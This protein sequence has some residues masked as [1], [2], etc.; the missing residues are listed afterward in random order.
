MGRVLVL[1]VAL[2]CVGAGG[3]GEPQAATGADAGPGGDGD[4]LEWKLVASWQGVGNEGARRAP[5]NA[6]EAASEP[7]QQG[8]SRKL[9]E[10][11]WRSD[12]REFWKHL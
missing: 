11:P 6:L 9:V 5:A 4:A 1:V 10:F 12:L 3:C 7:Q 2:M 8:L